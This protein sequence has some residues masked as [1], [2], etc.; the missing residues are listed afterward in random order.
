VKIEKQGTQMPKCIRTMKDCVMKSFV[1]VLNFQRRMVAMVRI[2]DSID[3]KPIIMRT[4]MIKFTL[5]T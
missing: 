4:I 1:V 3:D 2:H 5:H